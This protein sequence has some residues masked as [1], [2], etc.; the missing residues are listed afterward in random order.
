MNMR[1]TKHHD[2]VLDKWVRLAKDHRLLTVRE[3]AAEIGMSPDALQRAV[4][5]ARARGDERAVYNYYGRQQ[6]LYQD[7]RQAT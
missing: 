6:K 7:F 3:I 2:D 4:Q 5:R 1:T